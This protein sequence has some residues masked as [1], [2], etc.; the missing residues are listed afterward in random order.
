MRNGEQRDGI[1]GLRGLVMM[2]IDEKEE[3][4]GRGRG[5]KKERRDS[6]ASS[7]PITR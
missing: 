3:E 2:V 4:D 7:H 1:D 6:D 5:F